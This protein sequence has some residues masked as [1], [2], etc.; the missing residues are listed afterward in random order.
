MQSYDIP[1]SIPRFIIETSIN[2]ITSR[3][4]TWTTVGENKVSI[5]H[6][7]FRPE[8]KF[9]ELGKDKI[10]ILGNPI[11]KNKMDNES[12]CCD[13]INNYSDKGWLK[14]ING[15]FLIILS[16]EKD[17]RLMVINS[18]F[19][20]PSFWYYSKNGCFIGS[21]SYNDLWLRLGELGRLNIN[22]KSFFDLLMFKRIFGN[23]TFDKDSIVLEPS[24]I[25][26]YDGNETTI[27]PY[28][29]P[30]FRYKTKSSLNESAYMLSELIQ[31]SILRKT[32][33][34][35]RFA[36][37]LSGGMDTRTILASFAKLEISLTCFTI[38]QFK[39]REVQVAQKVAKIAGYK[40]IYLPFKEDHYR[41]TFISALKLTSSMSIPMCMFLGFEDEIR[42]HAD[43]AFHGHGFDYFFQGM[44][45]PKQKFI[46]LG[47]ELNY[48]KLKKLPNDIVN[49]FIENVAF[50]AKG[51]DISDYIKKDYLDTLMEGLISEL[52]AIEEKARIICDSPLN[53]YEYLIFYNLSRHHTRGDP[54]G[55]NANVEQRTISFDNDIYEFYQSLP[56]EYRFDAR[57][58]RKCLKILNKQLYNLMSANTTYPIRASSFE[59]TLYQIRD[60][61][62]KKTGL[63]NKFIDDDFQR[64][65]LPVNYLLRNDLRH[66]VEEFLR[67]DRLETINFLDISKIK[68]HTREW[69]N[70]EKGGEQVLMLLVTADQ[71]LKQLES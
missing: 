43:I 39:N 45:I 34:F 63:K 3:G 27:E 52:K 28:Y 20:S 9:Y 40:H 67:S 18:R 62:L 32:Q 65:G 21:Y 26:T 33:D 41:R 59:K 31:M 7:N 51:A 47:Q 16:S 58:Q 57:I 36:L 50:R 37:F 46:F 61:F 14:I 5:F 71:F 11:Y 17:K 55:M 48:L 56:V 42:R 25:L 53:I 4:E 38:N 30:N 49:Y 44:Y 29:M 1:V 70:S 64:M 66:F 6:D 19:C 10:C 13:L 15:E 68:R 60:Y 69:L 12:L 35:K 8:P 23:K 54:E 2:N 24:S 22:I